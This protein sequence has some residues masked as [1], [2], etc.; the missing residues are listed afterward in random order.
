MEIVKSKF[1]YY[2]II[3]VT[4]IVCSVVYANLLEIIISVW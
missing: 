1:V 2:V 3:T 4:L